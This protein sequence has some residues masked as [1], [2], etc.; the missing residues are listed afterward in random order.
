MPG[1]EG[2]E[3]AKESLV[4]WKSELPDVATGAVS[5]SSGPTTGGRVADS[6]GHGSKVFLIRERGDNINWDRGHL[7]DGK[8]RRE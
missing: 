8:K 4:S 7:E 5:S 3:K 1:W 2:R 6:R